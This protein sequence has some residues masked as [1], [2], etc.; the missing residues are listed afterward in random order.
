MGVGV[1]APTYKCLTLQGVSDF[2]FE[3]DGKRKVFLFAP[4]T[5]PPSQ[6][7]P[8]ESA[9]SQITPPAPTDR[10]LIFARIFR[11][12]PEISVVAVVLTAIFNV[13]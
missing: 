5:E 1:A 12:W 10:V 3:I 13:G 6:H 8:S 2:H 4:M 9:G 11:R 7:S